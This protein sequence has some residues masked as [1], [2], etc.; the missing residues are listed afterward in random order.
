MTVETILVEAG[1][2]PMTIPLHEPCFCW[3]PLVNVLPAQKL[4]KLALSVF[5]LAWPASAPDDPSC[6]EPVWTAFELRVNAA[7]SVAYQLAQASHGC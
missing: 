6:A 4:M 3:M 5:D 1:I 2:S 7:L